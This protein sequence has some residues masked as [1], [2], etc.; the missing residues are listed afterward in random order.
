[1]VSSMRHFAPVLATVF[2]LSALAADKVLLRPTPAVADAHHAR[3]RDAAAVLPWH[4]G[5]WLGVEVPVP[6]AAVEILKPNAIVTREYQNIETGERVTML[7]IHVRDARDI[8]GHYPPVCYRSQGWLQTDSRP[9]DWQMSDRTLRG[10][11]YTFSRGRLEGATTTVVD[12]FLMLPGG[13]TCRDMDGIEVAAQD[14]LW[15]LFGAS[16][17]QFIHDGNVSPERRRQVVEEILELLDPVLTAISNR[18]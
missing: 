16:Q 3:V 17:V 8:I 13:E 6:Q 9:S 15:K 1:M 12:N 5:P 10:T 2:V 14:R 7:L 11:E 18:D 4:I